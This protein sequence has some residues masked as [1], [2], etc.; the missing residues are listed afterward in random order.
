MVCVAAVALGSSTYAWFVTNTKVKAGTVE[1]SATTANTLL[2]KNENNEWATTYTFKD[3]NKNFVP[4]STIGKN[5]TE[6]F[7]FFIQNDWAKDTDNKITVNKVSAATGSEYWTKDFEI[8]ASQACKLYLDT[9]TT[10]TFGTPS[11]NNIVSAA[12]KALTGE[13]RALSTP[14]PANGLSATVGQADELYSFT[15]N[16]EVVKIKAYIWME[17]CDYDCNNST[18]NE[19]TGTTNKITATLGFCAGSAQ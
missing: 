11:A 15:E 12:S 3:E 7:D 16:N 19:I 13:N 14:D 1:I 2:I 10:D 5:S 4:V 9:E 8:K 18:V 6:A 17:G